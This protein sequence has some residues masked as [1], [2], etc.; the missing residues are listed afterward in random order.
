MVSIRDLFI[1]VG[2]NGIFPII[3]KK[4]LKMDNKQ[5]IRRLSDI[6]G[7][8]T[9]KMLEAIRFFKINGI[10]PKP[11]NVAD[12]RAN[13]C[14]TADSVVGRESYDG[15]LDNIWSGSAP[16][17]DYG[18]TLLKEVPS[19]TS[20]GGGAF[21]GGGA[22]SS[23]SVDINVPGPYDYVENIPLL[24][25]M[26][27]SDAYSAA[28][29][30]GLGEFEFNGRMYSNGYDPNATLGPVQMGESLVGNLRNVYDADGGI[31]R[32]S[33][34]VEPWVGQIPGRHKREH[35]Q[36][37]T[38]LLPYNKFAMGGPEGDGDLVGPPVPEQ[39]RR[40]KQEKLRAEMMARYSGGVGLP[41][42]RLIMKSRPMR[43][44]R[45]WMGGNVD[46]EVYSGEISPKEY[47]ERKGGV[48]YTGVGNKHR[49]N[50][51]AG[52]VFRSRFSTT[53]ASKKNE[54]DFISALFNKEMPMEKTQMFPLSESVFP[55]YSRLFRTDHQDIVG[56]EGSHRGYQIMPE[57]LDVATSLDS[58]A[59]A[60]MYD[61]EAVSNKDREPD[62]WEIDGSGNFYDAGKYTKVIVE[63]D[64]KKYYKNT[65][66][67]DVG[68]TGGWVPLF[69]KMANYVD[70]RSF[71]YLVVSPWH[72]Y[73]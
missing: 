61:I 34:R 2:W 12:A 70:S 51:N 55:L 37:G 14:N 40:E 42:D 27:F 65:D 67:F 64:G 15:L 66:V 72:E 53:E 58:L 43:V 71:P 29:R 24:D 52:G 4:I 69:G 59:N 28:R 17:Y 48:N 47:M 5:I 38:L 30:A 7:G 50:N 60:G 49:A 46:D 9:A 32:D 36:G 54:N 57:Y 73:K 44:L 25:G 18:Q 56:P 62:G 8:D 45:T 22:S 63:K 68:G 11:S 26:T 10:L 23:W 16:L 31:I 20:F 13:K 21:G 35:A 19:S 41:I 39:L 3:A 6:Y 33:T 1:P